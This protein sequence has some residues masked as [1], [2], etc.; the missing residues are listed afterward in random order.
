MAIAE[1][2]EEFENL[3]NLENF[4]ESETVTYI[5]TIFCS[6][7]FFIPVSV[8]VFM[9]ALLLFSVLNVVT[10]FIPTFL[11]IY[12]LR[13]NYFKNIS[14]TEYTVIEVV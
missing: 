10:C 5:V 1:N 13:K 3:E 4:K 2:L 12:F 11:I 8:L 6:I 7:V 9:T 14:T